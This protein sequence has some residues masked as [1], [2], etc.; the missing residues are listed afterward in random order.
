MLAGPA[1]LFVWNAS[2]RAPIGLC[3]VSH[4][5]PIRFNFV[6]AILAPKARRRAARGGLQTNN[7]KG[8]QPD[9]LRPF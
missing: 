7:I 1:P 4:A 5:V 8:P 3:W 2:A 6:L 9:W